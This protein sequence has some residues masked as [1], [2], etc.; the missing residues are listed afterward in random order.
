MAVVD[1]GGGEDSERNLKPPLAKTEQSAG[2]KPPQ[3]GGCGQEARS[4]R[5]FYYY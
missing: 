1:T 2:R 3:V 5:H 4:I